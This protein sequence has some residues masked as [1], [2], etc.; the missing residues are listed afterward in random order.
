MGPPPV[1]RASRRTL[2]P[3]CAVGDSTFGHI[4]SGL[5]TA[6]IRA[7]F[8]YR[9]TWRGGTM[10]FARTCV[11]SCLGQTATCPYA[12]P[13]QCAF[14]MPLVQRGVSGDRRSR[15]GRS[16]GKKRCPGTGRR[17][18]LSRCSPALPQPGRA[19]PWSG[20]FKEGL[21]R[22]SAPRRSVHALSLRAFASPFLRC[23]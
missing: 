8:D 16:P 10:D 19:I 15:T 22:P 7:F 9:L 21:R 3:A 14:T 4:P 11:P 6:Q 13:P 5:H 12:P 17:R 23:G 1:F 18:N 20:D 2:P